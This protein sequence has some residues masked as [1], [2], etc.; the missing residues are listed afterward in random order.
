MVSYRRTSN[1]LRSRIEHLR[2]DESIYGHRLFLHYGDL[3]DGTTLRRIFARVQP[4]EVYHLA[5]QSHVGLSFEIPESTSE[6]VA[7]ATLRLLEI[8]RDQPQPLRFYHA[9]S[10]EIFG[11]AARLAANGRDA[12][13]GRP[14]PTVARR[15]LRLSWR[16]FTGRPTDSLSATGFSTITNR[17]GAERTS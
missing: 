12:A 5:G 4:A 15:L 13:F 10:S 6:E 14:A 9:S 2:A 1:L 3:T 17:R 16:G 11:D 8:S 7:M